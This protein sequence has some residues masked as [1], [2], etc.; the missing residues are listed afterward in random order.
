VQWFL[1]ALPGAL[2]KRDDSGRLSLRLGEM[3]ADF[4]I[5]ELMDSPRQVTIRSLPDKL[6]AT[7]YTLNEEKGGTRVTVRLT[8][9]EALAEDAREDRLKLSGTA[10][11]N[12]LQNL[13][14][15]IDGTELPFPQAS[16]APLFGY[17]REPREK[18]AVE[19]SIWIAAPRERVWRAISNPDQ[20]ELWFSPGTSF[21][22][23]G[24]G[25]GARL[26][27]ENPETGAEMYVQILEVIDPP[28]HLVL[29][30]QPEPPETP[31]ITSYKLVEEN[32][33]TRLTL[34]YS[35]Y[36]RLPGDIRWRNMEENAFGFG[37]MLANL[38]AHIEGSSLP[39]PQGF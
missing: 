23:S 15:Y 32:N 12:A 16:V 14:A 25:V 33:G 27:V 17:W 6:I 11:E 19:R 29:R 35:G 20:F 30:S 13:K 21:K 2:M 3:N 37:M 24:S 39:N 1:P 18:I 38:K 9:F 22:S 8:G 36:E 7:T 34:T 4:A 26:Y 10:W 31:F 5:L 28:N